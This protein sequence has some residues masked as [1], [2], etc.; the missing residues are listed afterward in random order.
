[1]IEMIKPGLQ[2]CIQDHPGRI[3]YRAQGF[4]PS[5][6]MDRWSFRLANRLVGNPPGTAALECQFLGPTIRFHADCVFAVTGANMEP[7]LDDAPIPTWESLAARA[8]QLLALGRALQG[9]RA[10]LAVAGGID[11]PASLGSASTFHQAGVGGLDGRALRAG[12]RPVPRHPRLVARGAI[13]AGQ[14]R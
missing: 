14:G 9:A 12:R 4:P 11:A 6:P 7:R 10:Y 3:G 2:T 13:W 1:M 8:G 5:G